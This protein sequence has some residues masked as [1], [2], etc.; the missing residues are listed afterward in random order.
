MDPK[1][2]G[3]IRGYVR[4]KTGLDPKVGSPSCGQTATFPEL[5]FEKEHL[6]RTPFSTRQLLFEKEHLRRISFFTH[7]FCFLEQKP[8]GQVLLS[9]WAGTNQR[10]F[11]AETRLT[12]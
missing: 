4:P 1:I 3:Q 7:H 10:V 5:L 11:P 12:F 9:G 8:R 6:R 2:N